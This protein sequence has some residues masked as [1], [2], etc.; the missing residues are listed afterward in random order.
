[1]HI[2]VLLNL[3][4]FPVSLVLRNVTETGLKFLTYWKCGL[5][6]WRTV[7]HL[8]LRP[9]QFFCGKCGQSDTRRVKHWYQQWAN[10]S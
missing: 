5:G 1:M 6:K 2:P 7:C 8:C 3:S 9:T 4:H 10:Q